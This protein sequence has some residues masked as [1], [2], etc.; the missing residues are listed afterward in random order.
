MPV[1]L[2]ELRYQDRLSY[3]LRGVMGESKSSLSSSVGGAMSPKTLFSLT[4]GGGEGGVVLAAGLGVGGA[5]CQTI[6]FSD[7]EDPNN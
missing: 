5:V 2:L 4:A 6:K 7:I 1:N 3:D